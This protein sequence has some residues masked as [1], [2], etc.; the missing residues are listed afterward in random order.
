MSDGG[1]LHGHSRKKVGQ[2]PEG[3]LAVVFLA[4][5][6]EC[7]TMIGFISPIKDAGARVRNRGS[8]ESHADEQA[9]KKRKVDTYQAL[10]GA[11][12]LLLGMGKDSG[13]CGSVAHELEKAALEDAAFKQVPC[14][15]IA[16]SGI[17]LLK[18]LSDDARKNVRLVIAAD[19]EGKEGLYPFFPS[20]TR[21][22]FTKNIKEDVDEIVTALLGL[23][24][25]P[26]SQPQHTPR[27]QTGGWRDQ[28][29]ED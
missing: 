20:T 1:F 28:F 9:L 22:V 8:W 6:V 4:H 7:E 3:A 21:F 25:R 27:T 11:H 24:S 19:D 15:I 12:C 14:A 13:V 10:D 23:M 17:G 26:T 2:Q 18:D 5:G 16:G 29:M